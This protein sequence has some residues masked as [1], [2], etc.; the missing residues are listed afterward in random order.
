[1]SCSTQRLSLT[2][3][4]GPRG[5]IAD[6]DWIES[7]DQDPDG[8]VRLVQLADIGEGRFI[9]KSSRFLTTS[10]A[11]SLRCT[12]LK[13]G[14][15]LIAR[16]PDPIGRACI[17]PENQKPSVTAVDVCIVR[18][19]GTQVDTKW[20]MHVLNSPVIR[21]E[22]EKG[23]TGTTR[24][25]ISTGKLKN[26]EFNV[27]SLEEQKRIAAILDKADSL[28]RKCLQ[29][30]R[31]ADDFLRAVFIEMFGDPVTNPKGW[32]I[33]TL[34][35]IASKE[36]YS[37]VDGPF[38][39]AL[40]K[41][42]YLSEGVPIIR[43]KNI[44][45]NG[46]FLNSGF[47]YISEAKW[48]ENRRSAV[49]RDD[50]LISRVGTLGNCCIYPGGYEKALLSTTGVCKVTIDETKASNIFVHRM[51]LMPRFQKQIAKSAST[52]VQPYFNLS[53]LKSWKFG[54]PPIELQQQYA[55]ICKQTTRILDIL[56]Q[57]EN[58]DYLLTSSLQDKFFA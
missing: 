28:R 32:P 40:T 17:F 24:S 5:L 19:D 20:L 39:S 23:A 38:G 41:G 7:K 56:S 36:R 29:A 21:K 8:E 48:E 13:A 42:D 34:P 33:A 37:I 1:M 31:L 43:I 26:L 58:V 11:T 51:I 50:I 6:G 15:L 46:E 12:Y 35:D 55:Q 30:I 22:I 47:L 9:D 57:Q 49:Q 27:P 52:S 2:K 45:S 4:V 44:S 53:A 54:L 10:T 16:M 14:D 3:L 18:P 25:R